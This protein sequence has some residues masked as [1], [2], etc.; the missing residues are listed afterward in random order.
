MLDIIALFIK[1]ND[2]KTFNEASVKLNI[3][4][5][6]LQRKIKKLEEDLSLALFYREK[7]SLRLTEPGLFRKQARPRW[8]FACSRIKFIGSDH[9]HNIVL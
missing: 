2:Y 3:P 1:V 9:Q 5:P 4:L 7:G 8:K 6:T